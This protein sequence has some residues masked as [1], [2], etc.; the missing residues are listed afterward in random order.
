[1]ALIT[2]GKEKEV[3]AQAVIPGN[4]YLEITSIRTVQPTGSFINDNVIEKGEDFDIIMEVLF[5]DVLSQ[6]QV[7]FVANLDVLNLATGT[8]SVA[9][10]LKAS[11]TLP[12]GGVSQMTLREKFTATE[13]GIFLL[14]GSIGFPTSKLFDFSMGSIAGS[15]GPL[16]AAPRLR[17]ANFYVYD[18]A[19][20]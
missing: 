13:T 16:P 9:Y 6:L 12:G 18:P 3:Q 15:E 19:N 20:P 8:K 7:K 5:R 14:C 11:N 10:S 1:M 4:L 17:M 2:F